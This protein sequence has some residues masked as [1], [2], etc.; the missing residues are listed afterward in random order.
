MKYNFNP[1]WKVT[2]GDPS[3]AESPGFDDAAWKPVTL[4]CAWNEDEAFQKDIRNLSTGIAWYR[5]HFR[6]PDDAEGRKVFLEFEG[7]RQAAEVYL[8]GEYLGISENGVTA[9]GFD[10]TDHVKFGGNDNVVAVR[11]DNSW[12]YAEQATG[13]RFRWNDRNF[14]ANYGGL[15]KNVF[16]H[17]TGPVYQTL[18]LFSSLGTTGTY[19]YAT[20]FD[21]KGGSATITAETQVRNDGTD[22]AGFE[23]EV[24]VADPDGKTIKT[25]SG[26][27]TDLNRGETK[28]ITASARISGL[29]FWSWGYGY[30]YTVHTIL[31]SGG[32]EIDRVSTRTGFRKTEFSGGLIRLNDRVIMIK[33][34][35]QRTTN[36]WPATGLSVPPWMSD[37]SNKMMVESNGNLVR[38]MHVTPWKQDVESC[39]RVGL[40]EAMP[41]GDSE[42]DSKGRNWEQRV[43]V[44]RDA[45]I[46]NRNNPSIIFYESGNKG[47]SEEHM[48]EMK[49]LR[50]RYDPHGGRA[51][52]C[53]EMLDSKVAEYG[54]EMLYVNKSNDKPLWAMEYMR[55]EGLR[56]YWDEYSPPYHKDGDGPLYKGQNASAYNRNQDSYAHENVRRWYDYYRERPGSGNRV[57]SGG[58]NIIFSGTNTHHRGAENY[59]RSGETDPLRIPKDGYFAH[60]VMWNGWVEP[61]KDGIHIVGHWNYKEGVVKKVYVVSTGDEV[62]LFVNN[63][64]LGPGKKEFGFLFTFDSVAWEAGALRAVA[65][66]A[67]GRELSSETITTAGDPQVIKLSLIASPCGVKAD[68]RDMAMVQVE[69]VDANG[70]RCPTALNTIDFELEGAAEWRGG[71]ARGPGNYIL[72]RSLPVECGVNRVLIRSLTKSGIVKLSAVSEGLEGADL[73]FETRPVEV[74]DGLSP[75]MPSDGLPVNLERGPT[76]EGPSYRPFRTSVTIAG[77]RAGANQDQAANSYDGSQGTRWT[78]DGTLETGWI[79]YTLEREA[80]VSEIALKLSGWR[81]RRYPIVVSA[82]DSVVYRGVT[83]RNL[84]Y[85]YITPA[86]AVSTDNLKIRLFGQSEYD[87]AYKNY[88]ITGHLDKETEGDR[89]VHRATN[90]N[91]VEIEVFEMKRQLP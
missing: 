12:D 49:D 28:I 57:S 78:N 65:R 52:G 43:E 25:F 84:G 74:V 85:F 54:G 21:I 5:K 79:E 56:K 69:V 7:A 86:L 55:D 1:G 62:E 23:Y 35:A 46:Y 14:N 72:S 31:K 76:P 37:F 60:Q 83:A 45:I 80:L 4:P 64:S 73:S 63:K 87:D 13:T 24:Q 90:L 50:D 20:N 27:K 3:G 6:L 33:G 11:T 40:M 34:Y 2:T 58:V 66:D 16:L 9:F 75:E 53:R 61:E 18:P 15:V 22:M 59:R 30:L 42:G 36:E 41:A 39:D 81:T 91:I 29:H 38:W 88:E 47:I 70:Q 68:G 48:Q 26:E 71:M 82:N 67:G 77:A 32:T 8:N 44:M 19:I 89:A 10:I 17:V 51:A